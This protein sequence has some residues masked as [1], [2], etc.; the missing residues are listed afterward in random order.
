MVLICMWV[1]MAFKLIVRQ[2]RQSDWADVRCS[3][4]KNTNLTD[5]LLDVL[6]HVEVDSVEIPILHSTHTENDG[7]DQQ[8]HFTQDP[9]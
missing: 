7:R 9:D 4:T 2:V 3:L 8:K 6:Q 1:V 5:L